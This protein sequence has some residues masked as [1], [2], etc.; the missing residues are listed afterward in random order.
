MTMDPNDAVAAARAANEIMPRT[1]YQLDSFGENIVKTVRLL[2]APLQVASYW[3]DK[4][5]LKIARA[6]K[7]VPEEK[8]IEPLQSLALPIIEKLR[9]QEETNPITQLYI[10]LLARAMDRERI[11]EAHPAFFT[12]ITQLAPDE[13]L[14]L[15]ELSGREETLVLSYSGEK[16]YPP[17]SQRENWFKE[18]QFTVEIETSAREAMF[19]YENLIQPTLYPV[20]QEHLQNLGLVE[21]H[22]VLS[23]TF[24]EKHAKY[25]TN[26]IDG[27]MP[28]SLRLTHFGLL[29]IKACAEND[30]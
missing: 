3:Q 8:W 18:A 19:K 15:Q 25:G 23:R 22:N 2:L 20:F 1:V 16:T 13:L 29:F 17:P 4:L 26:R 11:G 30:S 5:E 6:V 21:Y 28:F 14:Y 24:Y 7:Q 10:N 9:Y 12:I 27:L